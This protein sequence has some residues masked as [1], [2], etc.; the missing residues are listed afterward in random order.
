MIANH[1]D[2]FHLDVCLVVYKPRW[3]ELCAAIESLNS[4]HREFRCLR[5][6]VSGNPQS[7]ADVSSILKGYEGEVVVHH[8][9]DNLGFAAGQNYLLS[10][11]F[12]QGAR[13]ACTFNPDLVV[14]SGALEELVTMATA[15]EGGPLQLFGP[16]I[17]SRR[18]D[19]GDGFVVDSLGIAWSA[20][21]RHY[22]L[23]AGISWDSI[24]DI[25]E[26]LKGLT[27]ACLLV[28]AE[29][30]S[31]VTELD[32]EFFDETFI[33]Y[34]EDADLGL[35][36][37]LQGIPSISLRSDGFIHK[38]GISY[39]QRS[40]AIVNLLSVQ[41]R[42]LMLFKFGLSRPGV[43]PIAIFRDALVVLGCL[44]VERGSLPGLLSAFRLRRFARYK[45]PHRVLRLRSLS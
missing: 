15:A 32:G 25:R 11:C 16:W 43:L 7:L 40:S 29:C 23:G 24:P 30:Y 41:N 39:G 12:L 19:G 31:A 4:V 33:A 18:S 45:S 42:F 5:V 21:A 38:R 9:F 26:P 22:D 34:R 6:L 35:R 28:S 13:W 27:G 44:S 3:S 36:C 37:A 17:K 10:E 1:R 14:R 2:G 20:S 8:R